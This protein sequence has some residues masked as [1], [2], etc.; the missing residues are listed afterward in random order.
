MAMAM[1]DP[2]LERAWAYRHLTADQRRAAELEFQQLEVLHWKAQQAPDDPRKQQALAQLERRG[3]ELG[4]AM[5]AGK[6]LDRAWRDVQKRA[7]KVKPPIDE[8]QTQIRADVAFAMKGASAP[9][10]HSSRSS[11][12]KCVNGFMPVP[13]ICEQQHLAAEEYRL[14]LEREPILRL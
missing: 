3:W 13:D 9:V 10:D 8:E 12:S 5:N 2:A 4:I 6:I 1:R 11:T 7:E 14:A